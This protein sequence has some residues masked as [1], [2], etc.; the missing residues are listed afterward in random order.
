MSNIARE[1]CAEVALDAKA[2]PTATAFASNGRH[3]RATGPRNAPLIRRP[4]KAIQK[5]RIG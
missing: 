1:W 2:T 4:E 3:L 5:P